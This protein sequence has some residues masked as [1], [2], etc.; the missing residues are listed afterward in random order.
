[1]HISEGIVGI[2]YKGPVLL[3]SEILGRATVFGYTTA[4]EPMFSG[5]IIAT[6]GLMSTSTRIRPEFTAYAASLAE[7][8]YGIKARV[9]E[10]PSERDQNFHLLDCEGGQFVLKIG[11]PAESTDILE[12]QNAAMERVAERVHDVYVPRVL[13]SRSG[14]NITTIAGRDGANYFVRMV[15]YLPATVMARFKPHSAELLNSLGGALGKIDKSLAEFSHPAAGR[16]LKW[17]V[18]RADWIRE[19]AGEVAD[20]AGRDLVEQFIRQF[21]ERARPLLSR[22]RTQVIHNDANDYNVLVSCDPAGT[23][24]VSGIIDFG[25]LVESYTIG[26]L[27]VALAYAMLDK[28]DPIGAARQVVAGYHREYTI[29]E[30]ELEVLYSIICIRLCVSVVNSAIEARNEPDNEYLRISE[31]PAWQLLEKLSAVSPDFAHYAFRDACGMAPCPQAAT[32]VDWL[33]K[34]HQQI[35][36]VVQADLK[37]SERIILDLSV[38]SPDLPD[39]EE[40][41]DIHLF[42]R[43]IF[44]LMSASNARVAVGRYDEA[45]LLY[46]SDVF[47]TKG[48]GPL[49]RRSVHL[50]IDL[51]MEDGE[52]V[53]CPIDGVVHGFRNNDQPLDYGPTI[54]IRH[55]P[56]GSKAT[57]FTLYGHLSLDSLAGLYP[58]KPVKKGECIGRI[59]DSSING[60]WL[61]HLH[62]QIIADML[63]NEGDFQGVALP[64]ERNIW[65]SICPDANLVLGIDPNSV[66]VARLSADQ[67]LRF[68]RESIGPSLSVA[69]QK[70]LN[71]VRGFMQYLYDDAGRVYVDAVNN[72]P[73]VGHCHPEVVRSAARQ[74]AVLNTNTRYLHESIVVFARRLA[75]TMPD[76]LSVCFFVCSGSEA[77]ELAIRMARAHTGASDI[78]VID[79]AYHGNTTTLVEISPYKFDGP[80]GGGAREWVHK[81]IMPDVFRGPFKAGDPEAGHKY[82]ADVHRAVNESAGAGHGVAAFISES[83]LG[84]GGQI[85][86]PEG[87]L[88]EAYRHAREAG[89]VC[90]ADEVQTGLGR[91]GSSFWAFETQGVAPDIVTVGKPLGNGHPVAAVVTTPQI[92]SS[93]DNGMEYFNTFGGNP[94]SCAAGMAVLDVIER[95]GLQSRAKIVGERLL[96]GL[97]RLKARHRLVG[98]VRGMGLF[99]GIELVLDRQTLEPAPR[100]A[101]YI[102]ERMKDKGILIS[103][104]GPL[105]NVLKIK[106]PLVFSEEN[107]DFLVES[108]DG[109][110][111]ENFVSER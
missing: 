37:G 10:L 101:S 61:P 68:R 57:F 75:A 39:I 30:V 36:P 96:S 108:L 72:V 59:G 3:F 98:D 84:C 27:A 2:I 94:V 100:Q 12:F 43:R 78:I 54:I 67:I 17:D 107:A 49:D 18:K 89:A 46:V 42:T 52:P 63:G 105:H 79:G 24:R 62:F 22:L 14:Q 15:S 103:T 38:G 34:N 102:I 82:A 20:L 4:W 77:N 29:T 35:G 21:D 93:F 7:D 97:E 9:R 45:R 66:P 111:G 41:E 92:A 44:D 47:K 33:K 48:G 60:G 23:A 6:G 110:L 73:H 85:V 80:G 16:E 56:D 31:R 28:P 91:V 32:V 13:A 83:M 19:R 8:L 87:Y 51:F 106:P 104:D 53:M 88:K 26:E 55:E 40:L 71:I 95:E 65:L 76:P 64:G 50:G 70:P 90:I 109:V 11:N 69:Y 99:A 58:G 81:V 74:M 25:D 86:L 5:A 1:M